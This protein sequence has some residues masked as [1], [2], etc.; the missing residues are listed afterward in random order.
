MNFSCGDPAKS[1]DQKV[2]IFLSMAL[3]SQCQL[4]KITVVTK[5]VY[6]VTVFLERIRNTIVMMHSMRAIKARL[7]ALS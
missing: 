7:Y 3:L 1:C 4:I 2:I 6:S 5:Q